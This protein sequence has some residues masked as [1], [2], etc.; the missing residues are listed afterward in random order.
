MPSTPPHDPLW[1]SRTAGILPFSSRRDLL[2][3]RVVQFELPEFLLCAL[4]ARV[5]EANQELSSNDKACLNDYV[6]SELA[7]IITLRDVAELDLLFPG[8]SAAVEKW[9]SDIRS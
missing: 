2:E 1:Q 9:L 5:A 4:E 3:R 6:E 8:F 7:N